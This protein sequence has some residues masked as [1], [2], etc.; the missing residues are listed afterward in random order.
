[1]VDLSTTANN[2]TSG[3]NQTAVLKLIDLGASVSRGVREVLPPAPS[4]LEFAAPELVLGQPVGPHT[5][6]WAAAVFLYVFLSG[7]SFI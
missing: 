4:S 5:D 7:V 1:M 3:A 6:M 2:C